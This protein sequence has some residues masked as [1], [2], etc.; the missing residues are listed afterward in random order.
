MDLQVGFRL[1]EYT[2][3]NYGVEKIPVIGKELMKAISRIIGTMYV[4]V[5]RLVGYGHGKA[6]DVA[7]QYLCVNSIFIRS[8]LFFLAPNKSL[9]WFWYVFECIYFGFRGIS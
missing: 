4:S 6:T 2:Y 9:L 1:L 3:L 8:F 5:Q 7:L